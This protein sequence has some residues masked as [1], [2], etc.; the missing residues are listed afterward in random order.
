MKSIMGL[1]LMCFSVYLFAQPT[2][3]STELKRVTLYKK[4]ALVEREGSV[5]LQKGN[6][7]IYIKDLPI[8]LMNGSVVL[9]TPNSVNIISLEIKE[10]IDIP[11]ED[12]KKSK[13]I[14]HQKMLYFDSISLSGKN[15]NTLQVEKKNLQQDLYPTNEK[16]SVTTYKELLEYKRTRIFNIDK[17]I[18]S[19]ERKARGMKSKIAKLE[20]ELKIYHISQTKEYHSA[21]VLVS[22]EVGG[23]HDFIIQ[24]FVED[25]G[26]V[27][28]YDVVVERI[29]KPIEL[30]HKAEVYQES[31]EDWDDVSL[32]LSTGAPR[33]NYSVPSLTPYFLYFNNYFQN[34]PS[35]PVNGYTGK[36][37]SGRVTD[38]YGEALIGASIIIVGTSQGTIADVGGSFEISVPKGANRIVVSF[39]GYET[40]TIPLYAPYLDIKLRAGEMLDEAVVTGAAGRKGRRKRADEDS[41]LYKIE[42]SLSGMASGISISEGVER[43]NPTIEY[44][45]V[46]KTTIKGMKDP[47]TIQIQ[48]TSLNTDLLY[49]TIPKSEEAAYLFAKVKNWEQLNLQDGKYSVHFE[50]KYL[51]NYALS[52]DKVVDELEITLGVDEDIKVKRTPI[53]DFTKKVFLSK[54]VKEKKSW[55]ITV[56]NTKN[57][58]IQIEVL[59]QYPISKEGDIKVD[60]QELSDAKKNEETGEIT[61]SLSLKAKVKVEKILTY[62]VKYPKGQRIVVE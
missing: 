18:L 40:Q 32:T 8:D 37:I 29:D 50:G 44:P 38:E 46:G 47:K 59:D 6:N 34:K 19:L 16:F 4:G 48:T 1:L 12:D 31:S 33:F 13:L 60:I 58:P 53:K 2:E 15:I 28:A 55:K 23:L 56:V 17:K 11:E 54:N 42:H 52:L 49:R 5:N 61:W 35:Q 20:N 39:I 24:Y 62:E 30:I 21:S 43:Y 57:V 41:N 36:S 26:W 3:M 9:K 45:L 22:A 7:S 27:P 10:E 51:T 14:N 25:A